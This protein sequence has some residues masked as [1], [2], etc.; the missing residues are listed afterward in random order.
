MIA[1]VNGA[2][3]PEESATVS[4]FDRS[5]RY[6]DGLF[7]TI[8][9]RNGKPF[10]WQQHMARLKASAAFFAIPLPFAQDELRSIT[11]ELVA[12]NAMSDAILRI[13]LSR[14]A[15]PRGYAPSGTEEPTVVMTLHAAAPPPALN[16]WSLCF[17]GLR[18]TA[19]DPL[20]NHKTSSRM[21]HVLVAMEAKQ[22]GVDECLILNTDGEV[23]EAGSCNVFWTR[24]GHVFTPPFSSGALPGITR[25]VVLECCQALGIPHREES[26]RAERLI[27]QDGVFL[28][29][30]SRGIVE[31][32]TIDGH[33]L[34]RSFVTQ[35]L[36]AEVEKRIVA[37][38]R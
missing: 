32:R 12:R 26:I 8:L 21:L 19:S 33:Q 36:Q 34:P 24:D 11:S 28:S 10:R 35:K 16:S 38:C 9:V 6:G 25:A 2:W 14:G 37:E 30:T 18:V 13:Q 23:A 29:L 7:E 20:T 22:R 5:F 4:I 17:S 3:L 31:A 1:F 15:G 27:Q